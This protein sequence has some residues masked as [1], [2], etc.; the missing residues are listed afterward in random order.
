[1]GCRRVLGYIRVSTDDQGW[2]GGG[3]AAQR[4]AISAEAGRRGWDVIAI[5]SDIASAKDMKRRPGLGDAVEMIE[6]GGADALVVSKLDRLSRSLLDFA[7]LMERAERKSWEI[8]LLA[9]QFDMT[10]SSG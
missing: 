4:D 10:T 5:Y 6:R 7:G 3:M 8:I 9:E 1:M 2:V